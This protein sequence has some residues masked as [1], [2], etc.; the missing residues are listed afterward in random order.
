[1]DAVLEA[2]KN[3]IDP[4]LGINIVDLGLIYDIRLEGQ[5]IQVSMTMTTPACP[6]SATL[7][8]QAASV[9]RQRF[10]DVTDVQIDLVWEPLW[11]PLMMSSQIRESLG[12]A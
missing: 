11:H 4:E 10:P 7:T 6:L 1:M 5:Q 9:L 12:W 2:L 8:E 3:V